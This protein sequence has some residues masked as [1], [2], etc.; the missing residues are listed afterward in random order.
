ML[1]VDDSA[2]M[3]RFV[4]DYFRG[5]YNVLTARNGE[6]ALERLRDNDGIDL[7]VSDITMPKMN[8][9]ELC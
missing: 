8:G 1:M 5:E 3:C 7:V 4:R 9:F 2:D 6:E